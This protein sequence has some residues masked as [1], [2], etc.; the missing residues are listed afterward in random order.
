MYKT[1]LGKQS[2]NM[3]NYPKLID[4]I[5]KDNKLVKMRDEIPFDDIVD[6]LKTLYSSNTW[7]PSKSLRKLIALEILKKKFGY[8]DR[9]LVTIVNTDLAVM[10]FCGYEYPTVE[11]M[12]SS[13]MTKFRNKI[14]NETA[15]MIQ[16][17]ALWKA[18]KLLHWRKKWN[19][20]T[21]TTCIPENIEFPTDTS[22]LKK[23]FKKLVTIIQ[24]GKKFLWNKAKGLIIRW[25]QKIQKAIRSF[26][27]QR[28]KTQKQIQ[29]MRKKLVR[30]VSKLSIK[31]KDVIFEV[32]K[33]IAILPDSALKKTK[34]II[35]VI[36]KVI[37]QQKE[38]IAN[39]GKSVS[40]RIVS[41]HKDFVR[42][43]FRWKAKNR[44]E[45][46]AKV[47]MSLIGWKYVQI[48]SA[49]NEN[50]S[51]TKMPIKAIE[52]YEKVVSKKPKEVSTDR[53][54]HSPWNHEYC[55]E[56]NITD[57]IQYK[58]KV[59]KNAQLAS[60]T[61]RK[62]LAKERCFMEWIIWIGKRKYGLD[63]NT[64]SESNRLFGFIC[65]WIAMNYGMW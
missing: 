30:V 52:A 3:F 26:D 8:S 21:D 57:W 1:W 64:Y 60:V 51:D 53:W 48:V 5:P 43:I 59:P 58:W 37:E 45:F 36:D 12:D 24:D 10:Y 2:E 29:S 19:L 35:E 42:P 62:R 46:W 20:H 11:E 50:T 55:K 47:T 56:H 22:I 31:A 61:T 23:S 13:V 14:D 18:I 15:M 63:T 49:E 9:D 17:A 32:S 54:W 6:I 33:Q 44:T 28:N 25:K 39:K 7:A 34:K 27:L 40:W 65:S 38:L 16:D 4:L 41:L